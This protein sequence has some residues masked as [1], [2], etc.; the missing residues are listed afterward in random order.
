MHGL[1]AGTGGFVFL[2][3]YALATYIQI[4]SYSAFWC[5]VLQFYNLLGV[6]INV[7][8]GVLLKGYTDWLV[9]CSWK[10]TILKK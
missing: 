4:I 1:S 5:I 2:Q 9:E 7:K 10:N 3:R 8:L 6:E